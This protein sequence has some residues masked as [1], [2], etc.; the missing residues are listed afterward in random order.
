VRN[1]SLILVIV[2][3]DELSFFEVEYEYEYDDER[4]L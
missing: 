2:L 3:V 4:G 1:S